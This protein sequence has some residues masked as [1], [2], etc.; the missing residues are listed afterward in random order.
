MPSLQRTAIDIGESYTN[1]G[2]SLAALK[3]LQERIEQASNPTE[4]V[5]TRPENVNPEE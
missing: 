4:N 1:H 2:L 3:Q 5:T